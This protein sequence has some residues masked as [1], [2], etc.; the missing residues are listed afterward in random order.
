M[1]NMYFAAVV[2]PEHLDKK[3]LAYK[4]WMRE[5]F[6]CRVGLKSPAHITIVPPFWMQAEREKELK[7]DLENVSASISS[8]DISTNNFSAF[9]PRTL[10]VAV[11][12]NVALDGLKK[13]SDDYFRLKDY[14][15]KGE[16]RPFHPHITIATRD[17]PKGAFAEAWAHFEYQKFEEEFDAKGLSL[18]K[19]NGSQWEVIYTAAFK[20]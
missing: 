12:E 18:L 17:L 9:K 5:K 16:N 3:I 19:H 1:E 15:I 10:F 4:K 11:K 14:K 2:L 7:T 6:G 13:F 8:L 20:E